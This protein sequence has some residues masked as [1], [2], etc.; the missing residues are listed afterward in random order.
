[1]RPAILLHLL[2]EI[3]RAGEVDRFFLVTHGYRRVWRRRIGSYPLPDR[4]T[5]VIMPKQA[6][7]SGTVIE[8]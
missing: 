8:A 6:L 3:G 1:M 7:E 2:Q 4:L 5:C